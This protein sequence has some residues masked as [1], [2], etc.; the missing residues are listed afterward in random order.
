MFFANE[1]RQHQKEFDELNSNKNKN[2]T[3]ELQNFLK[4]YKIQELDFMTIYCENLCTLD[5]K[6]Y[7]EYF[8]IQEQSL[9]AIMTNEATHYRDFYSRIFKKYVAL[10]DR[11]VFLEKAIGVIF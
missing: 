8:D 6:Q 2:K 1:V 11:N 3:L 9:K 5:T 4:K 10:R 7:A